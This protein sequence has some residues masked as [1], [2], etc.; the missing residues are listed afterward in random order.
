L[1]KLRARPS[2]CPSSGP[3]Q[4]ISKLVTVPA[5]IPAP[6]HPSFYP[7]SGP[8]ELLS[9]LRTI[10]AF[11][12]ARVRPSFYPGSG[13]S[14]L[15]SK[16]GSVRAFIRA[17][18]HPSFYPSSGPSQLVS[19]LCPKS[20]PLGRA[21][22]TRNLSVTRKLSH[23]SR[24]NF[25]LKSR[26]KVTRKVSHESRTKTDR[27]NFFSP[28]FLTDRNFFP[29][30]FLADGMSFLRHLLNSSDRNSDPHPALFQTLSR[31]Q[32]CSRH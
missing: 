8:S 3:S 10:P 13:P 12:Q 23:E 9:R 16:L 29:P 18:D 15:L 6:D 7:S 25:S 21:K 4:L 28:M 27:R 2:F 26:T 30:M 5:F 20:D 19:E 14:Q 24:T 22:V 17:R 31:P 32:L 11:I 1:A